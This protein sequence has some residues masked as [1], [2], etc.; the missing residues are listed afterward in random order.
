[1]RYQLDNL[2]GS[3]TLEV[4]ADGQII[5]YEEY[6]PYGG[7][8]V[9]AGRSA[10]E[11]QLKQYRYSGK[12]RDSVTGF[13]YYGVRY[14]APWLGRW[15]SPDPAGPMDGLNLFAFV[16]N[17]PVDYADVGGYGRVK[18]GAAKKEKK[19]KK[20]FS[21]KKDIS[22]GYKFSGRPAFDTAAKSIKVKVGKEDRRHVLGL[23][24]VIRPTYETVANDVISKVGEQ[25][26]KEIQFKLYKKHKVSRA[27]KESESVEKHLKFGLT[28]LNS[29]PGNLNPEA[30]HENQAIEHVRQQGLRI[31]GAI[32]DKIKQNGGETLKFGELKKVIKDGF[33]LSQSGTPITDFADEARGIIQDRLDKATTDS[34]L[35]SIL[36]ESMVSTGIDL[37]KTSG[38]KEQTSF[39]LN[40]HANVLDITNP[41]TS[42]TPEERMDMVFSLLDMPK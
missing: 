36:K 31:E 15:M 35:L 14:Y 8:A 18:S 11:V 2:L 26:F 38:S 7:T 24:D 28:K 27:P 21:V 13:Y 32:E 4:D 25:K 42:K 41:D 5:S 12:E 6:F 10:S 9:I 22:G 39:A 30:A 23:D 37:N 29:V 3:A 40:Y 34:E 20:R 1:M 16:R 19:E 33:A 17:N